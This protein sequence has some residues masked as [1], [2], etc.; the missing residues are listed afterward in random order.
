MNKTEL[1]KAISETTQENQTTVKT[2]IDAFIAQTS[3]TLAE[4][5]DIT[6]IGFGTFCV[7]DRAERLG[8]NPRTNEDIIIPASK[9]PSF[10]AGK[11]LKELVNS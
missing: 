6:L 10:K 8:R 5:D 9:N 7:K 11:A 1:I 3:S 2:I 4:G